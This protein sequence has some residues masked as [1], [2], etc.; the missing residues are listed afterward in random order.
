MALIE[1]VVKPKN[2]LSKQYQKLF[3]YEG[4][5]LTFTEEALRAIAK[6]AIRRN[7][8]ARGL[9]GVI[10]SAMLEIMFEIPSMSNVKECII[11]EGVI[12]KDEK[13]E[14][15]YGTKKEGKPSSASEDADEANT[16]EIA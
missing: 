15:I 1:I 14:L 5:Q 9:R 7:T 8:G 13:P 3:N 4:V 6:E 2:A 10:E 11:T 12:V 16:S